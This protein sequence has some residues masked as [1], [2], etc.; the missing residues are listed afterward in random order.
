[1]M[2]I[3]FVYN[4]EMVSFIRKDLESLKNHFQVKVIRYCGITDLLKVFCGTLRSN[5]A[6]CWFASLNSFYVVTFSKIVGRRSIVVA[7]GYDV[8]FCPEIKYGHLSY[9]WK[10]W[11]SILTLKF[12]TLILTVSKRNTQETIENARANSSKIKLVYHGF[13][14]NRYKAN[15]D[16]KKEPV[17]LTVG[18]VSRSNLLRKGLELFVK[19]ARLLP[20]FKFIL[21]GKWVD[22][23]IDHLKSIASPNVCFLNNLDDT[24]LLDVFT[25]SKVYVQASY[26]EAFGCSL[27]EA[28]LCECIPVVTKVAALPEVVGDCGFFLTDRSP[29]KLAVLIEQALNSDPDLGKRARGRI[30]QLFPLEKREK[31]LLGIIEELMT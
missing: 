7:G 26:H 4:K 12:A 27:A 6:F 3:L 13:D 29:E 30:K 23:C 31:A 11:C 15:P 9:W 5:V 18:T 22:D 21:A 24:A 14:F 17:V 8:A 28:M 20:N 1:M 25:R 10:R 16:V 19:S 2:K